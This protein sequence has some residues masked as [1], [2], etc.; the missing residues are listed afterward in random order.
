MTNVQLTLNTSKYLVHFCF[1]F[2]IISQIQSFSHT[3]LQSDKKSGVKKEYETLFYQYHRMIH[4]C[5]L[6]SKKQKESIPLCY[7]PKIKVSPL[8]LSLSNRQNLQIL[9]N[10]F[11]NPF[12][13]ENRTFNKSF[14][15]F[16]TYICFIHNGNSWKNAL[17]YSAYL[18]FC[19]YC[20]IAFMPGQ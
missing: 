14:S 20:Q 13:S 12:K 10:R 1:S 11:T 3:V 8:P 4:S 2:S 9:S 6:E 7:P 18:C 5:L 17:L 15:D 19:A 16:I